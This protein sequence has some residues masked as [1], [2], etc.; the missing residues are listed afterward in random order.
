LI[1]TEQKK[2]Q[3]QVETTANK[4]FKQPFMP[5]NPLDL[6]KAGL[7]ELKQ[8]VKIHRKYLLDC[9]QRQ[10]KIS[11]GDEA[12]LDNNT[13]YIDEEAIIG[14]LEGASSFEHAFAQ[15]NL[16]QKKVVERLR[17][18]GR[19]NQDSDAS[20]SSIGNKRKHAS[21]CAIL[22]HTA[23]HLPLLRQ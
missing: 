23:K 14:A 9:L 6:L 22:S 13:N 12:W 20:E 8:G 18:L 21:V 7:F 5:E 17:E 16:K 11:D 3:Q 19:H 2:L 15:L 1:V 10:E 4:S